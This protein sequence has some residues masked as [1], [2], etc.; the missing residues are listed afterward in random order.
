M[1]RSYT[2]KINCCTVKIV[3]KFCQGIRVLSWPS[4]SPDLNIIENVWGILTRRVYRNG[5]Q[6][7]TIN[8]LKTAISEEWERLTITELRKLFATIPSRI[9][10][11]IN[12]NGGLT[13]Y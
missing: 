3:L 10:Q 8:E 12:R 5:R 9:F 1:R 7:N 13:K 11:V 2:F 4:L 6:F